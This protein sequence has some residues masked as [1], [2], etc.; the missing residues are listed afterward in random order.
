M[1]NEGPCFVFR[2]RKKKRKAF[3]TT[4]KT[5]TS[6]QVC[7]PFSSFSWFFNNDFLFLFF[8]RHL[9]M[10]QDETTVHCAQVFG[11]N[12]PPDSEQNG[13]VV[14]TSRNFLLFSVASTAVSC[15][16]S[17]HGLQTHNKQ[18]KVGGKHDALSFNGWK[19]WTLGGFASF[20]CSYLWNFLHKFQPEKKCWFSR[21]VCCRTWLWCCVST[22]GL[23]F[24]THRCSD[25]SARWSTSSQWGTRKLHPLIL[26]KEIERICFSKLRW[27]QPVASKPDEQKPKWAG[28]YICDLRQTFPDVYQVTRKLL[29]ESDKHSLH[30]KFLHAQMKAWFRSYDIVRNWR[31]TVS[32]CFTTHFFPVSVATIDLT[33]H[34]GSL[35]TASHCRVLES[36]WFVWVSQSNHI[37]MEIEEDLALPWVPQQLRATC[38]VEQSAFNDWFTG[39]LNFQIEHQW[40]FLVNDVEISKRVPEMYAVKIVC[41]YPPSLVEVV[42]GQF[43]PTL[44]QTRYPPV[45]KLEGKDT[46]PKKLTALSS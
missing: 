42:L 32:V 16:F 11:F 12:Q 23:R 9:Q 7:C 38:D 45:S 14:P 25:L 44:G 39:H 10:L 6:S 26:E 35:C 46:K 36:H 20:H 41:A 15:L 22:A 37:P 13:C 27:N 17:I 3:P 43:C 33:L 8:G 21:V 19:S 24:S 31:A 40:V 18:A 28:V 30:T 5:S 2:L 4:G 34:A 1:F 29:H